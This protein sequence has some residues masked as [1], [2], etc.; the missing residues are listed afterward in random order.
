MKIQSQLYNK[1]N[2]NKRRGKEI[3][4]IAQNKLKF[5]NKTKQVSKIIF[6]FIQIIIYSRVSKSVYKEKTKLNL[7]IFL[8]YLVI[9]YNDHFLKLFQI[10]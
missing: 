8:D 9:I 6:L 7:D 1:T 3:F 4:L 5:V 2:I 10:K